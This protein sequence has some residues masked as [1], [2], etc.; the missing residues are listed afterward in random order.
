MAFENRFRSACTTKPCEKRKKRSGHCGI[1]AERFVHQ[2]GLPLH[3]ELLRRSDG[4]RAFY[5]DEANLRSQYKV[6]K[7]A[8][9]T[10]NGR[11]ILLIDDVITTG[12]TA[13]ICANLLLGAGAQA[14]YVLAVAQAESTLKE[15]RHMGERHSAKIATLAPW[16]CLAATPDLGPVRVRSLLQLLK[17]PSAI[18]S[19]SQKELQAARGIGPKLAEAITVQA[20]CQ[21]EYPVVAAN[22]L[23]AADRIP[24]VE[25]FTVADPDYPKIL[26]GSNHAVPILFAAGTDIA[27]LSSSRVVAVVGSRRVIGEIRETTRRMAESLSNAGWTVA[28]GLAEG[29]DALAHEGALAGRSPTWAFLGCGVDQIYPPWNRRLRDTILQRGWLFSEYQ[30][31]TRVIRIFCGSVIT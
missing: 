31:G 29:C 13:G 19:A 17:N 5:A 6:N 10:I 8:E 14:V 3:A 24:G 28:S 22:L 21:H 9:R 25:V 20:A 16:L 11:V 26:L 4:E 15:S 27:G 7:D 18:L 2:A 1:F 30:F 23:A 12:R